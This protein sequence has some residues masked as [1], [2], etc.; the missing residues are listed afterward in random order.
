LLLVG[1]FARPIA[2]RLAGNMFV[3]YLAADRSA[4]FGVFSNLDAF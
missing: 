4:L 3:A 1:L 2:L